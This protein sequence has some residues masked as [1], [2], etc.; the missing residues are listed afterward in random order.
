LK[1]QLITG[2]PGIQPEISKAVSDEVSRQAYEHS[3]RF[4]K[5]LFFATGGVVVSAITMAL[6]GMNGL[7]NQA[8]G[9]SGSSTKALELEIARLKEDLHEERRQKSV[10]ACVSDR[11][12]VDKS[13][14]Y[15]YER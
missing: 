14:C 6:W 12:V 13:G 9:S 1:S 8:V 5:Y 2:K 15:R 7:V 10:A 4:I 3:N 11:K